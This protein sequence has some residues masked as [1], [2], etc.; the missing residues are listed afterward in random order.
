MNLGMKHLGRW[1]HQSPVLTA[2]TCE[3]RLAGKVSGTSIPSFVSGSLMH[4]MQCMA[5]Q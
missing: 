2:A 1:A 5:L 3:S 4:A